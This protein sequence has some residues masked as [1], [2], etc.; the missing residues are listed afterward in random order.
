[1]A[2]NSVLT[3][4]VSYPTIEVQGIV[5]YYNNM[6][7]NKKTVNKNTTVFVN[8]LVKDQNGF[9]VPLNNTYLFNVTIKVPYGNLTTGPLATGITGPMVSYNGITGPSQYFFTVLAQ[10]TGDYKYKIQ[11][12]ST[13]NTGSYGPQVAVATVDTFRVVDDDF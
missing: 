6:N 11:Y 3:S 8:A 12:D 5:N 9:I 4:I 7:F 1:M 2:L 10:T 13:Q